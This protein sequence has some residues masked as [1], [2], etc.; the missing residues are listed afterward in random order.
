MNRFR[1]KVRMDK[2]MGHVNSQRPLEDQAS[3]STLEAWERR[4]KSRWGPEKPE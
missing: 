3:S 1:R 2:P 4:E